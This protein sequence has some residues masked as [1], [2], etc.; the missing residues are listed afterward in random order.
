M[1]TSIAPLEELIIQATDETESQRSQQLQHEAKSK[2]TA[3]KETNIS[4]V[5]QITDPAVNAIRS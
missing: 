1:L 3:S 4:D 2:K 5:Q